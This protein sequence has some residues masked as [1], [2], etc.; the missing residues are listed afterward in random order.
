MRVLGGLPAGVAERLVLRKFGPSLQ[1]SFISRHDQIHFK[2]YAAAD[3]GGRHFTDL[4]KLLPTKEELR[5][6]AR[7]TFTQDAS[8]A[9][10]QV[11]GEVLHALGNGGPD[12]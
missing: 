6:A 1:V 4:E 7:W 10:R 2:L 11:V 5:A 3:Q 8:D 12:E 9:F